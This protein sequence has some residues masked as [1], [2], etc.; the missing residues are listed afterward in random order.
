MRLLM[1]LRIALKSLSR[2]RGRTFLTMLGI[3]IGVGSVI[4]MISMGQGVRK[5]SM[6]NIESRGSNLLV[7]FSWT[8]RRPHTP[9]IVHNPF[10]PGDEEIIEKECK[11]VLYASPQ[12]RTVAR[13][14]YRDNNWSTAI[15]G[16]NAR[17][18]FIRN[19][20]IQSGRFFT[21]REVDSAAKVAVIG[22]VVKDEL[23]GTENPIGKQIRIKRIPFTVIGLLE[24]KGQSGWHGNLDDQVI[25]PY[26]TVMR[27][28]ERSDSFNSL[29]ASA[30]SSEDSELAKEE[31]TVL[32]RQKHK[33]RDED[34]NDFNIRTQEDRR[35]AA[36]S[37]YQTF[38]ILLGAIASVSLLVGGIGIMNIMLVTVNERVREIGIRMAMGA[39]Q[40]DILAQFIIESM[41]LSSAGG[42]VGIALGIALTIVI[43]RIAKWPAIVSINSIIISF[44]FAGLIGVFFGF[45]PAYKA[46]SLN[47]I[48]ALRK[49]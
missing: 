2:N 29:I 34:E 14:I 20:E 31:I 26:T 1:S 11:H 28:I 44:V 8:H 15:L 18:Q 38:T 6:D 9:R 27:R 37:T 35:E 45:Y 30:T 33:L 46:S 47:P 16:G 4:A 40:K 23:F 41:V 49:E 25:I 39:R 48:E 24:P 36:E 32:L 22:A 12:I 7:I 3:I 43:A 10:K 17:F 5:K 42:L 19:W 13:V 21:S